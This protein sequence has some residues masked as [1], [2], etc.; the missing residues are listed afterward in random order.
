MKTFFFAVLLSIMCTS[1]SAQLKINLN[2][3]DDVGFA[4]VVNPKALARMTSDKLPIHFRVDWKNGNKSGSR[5]IFDKIPRD[6]GFL[7][8]GLYNKV[9]D[10]FFGGK[11]SYS[12][13]ATLNGSRIFSNAESV[14][15]NSAGM[16]YLKVYAIDKSGNYVDIEVENYDVYDIF[17]E[18]YS[19]KIGNEGIMKIDWTPLVEELGRH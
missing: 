18:G 12:I 2:N 19:A 16:K 10:G 4:A 17:W 13:S 15:D 14:R 3:I 11:Y 8:V 6:G 9:F 7:V 1:L 5:D